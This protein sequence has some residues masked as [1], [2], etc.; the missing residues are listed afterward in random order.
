MGKRSEVPAPE[1]RDA[2]LSF[3]RREDPV[4]V[5]ARR[6]G[7]AEATLYRWRDDLLAAGEAALASGMRNGVS[8]HDR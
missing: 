2:V 8:A 5:I 4:A 7:V 1:R 6:Y 3:S